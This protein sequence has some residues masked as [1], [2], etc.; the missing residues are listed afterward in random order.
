MDPQVIFYIILGI[1]YVLF[2]AFRSRN[3]EE[4]APPPPRRETQ[5]AEGEEQRPQREVFKDI[6]SEILG[7]YEEEERK[8]QPT[9]R[10]R[11]P[12]PAP[13]QEPQLSEWEIMKAERDRQAKKRKLSNLEMQRAEAMNQK[14]A[15]YNSNLQIGGDSAAAFD[16]KIDAREAIIHQ[17]ILDRPYQ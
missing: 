5:E 14:S 15:I 8:P 12:Q 16:K 2:Q 9:A 13:V 17:A 4:Q 11:T 3:Q 10:K 1:G 6:F 7:E